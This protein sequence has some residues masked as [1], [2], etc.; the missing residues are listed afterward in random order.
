MVS[1]DPTTELDPQFSE[2]DAAPVG[3]DEARTQL[4]RAELYWLSTV[5]PDGRPHVT[6]LIAVWFEGALHICTGPEERKARNIRSNVHCVVTTGCN[7]LHE[8]LD[9]VIE[10][11]AIRVN[12]N[13]RLQRI[14]DTYEAKYGQEWHFTV[15]NGAFH[16][17]PD[18]SSEPDTGA[19][20]VFAIAPT[21]AFGFGKH[22]YSQTRWSFSRVAVTTATAATRSAPVSRTSTRRT[23][24]SQR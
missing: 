10:G 15:H 11:D 23:A 5:R 14:A 12:N 20:F 16:H 18:P 4:E 9:V 6:P 24:P 2:P 22:P 1:T 19:A 21:T 3:W 8:G 13:A 7:T 17:T